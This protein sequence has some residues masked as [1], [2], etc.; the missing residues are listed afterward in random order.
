MAEVNLL[1]KPRGK[2]CEHIKGNITPET[3]TF[4][5]DTPVA[6]VFARVAKTAGLSHHRI[7]LTYAKTG[8]AHARNVLDQYK[9]GETI[10]SIGLQDGTVLYA[11]DLGPQL[12]WRT[13]YIIEYLGPLLLHPLYLL[14]LRPLVYGDAAR[15][16]A[17]SDLQYAQG[18]GFLFNSFRLK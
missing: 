4:P 12:G 15:A 3:L 2:C 1:I 14:Y 11:K 5:V 9:P 7:R 18:R 10:G 6:D 16:S 8:E 17:P 13:V